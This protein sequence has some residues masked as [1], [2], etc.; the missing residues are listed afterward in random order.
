MERRVGG[1]A[2]RG[3]RW[4]PDS[5]RPSSP[6]A[7]AAGLLWGGERDSQA[8]DDD[9]FYSQMDE[10]GIIG[11]GEASEEGAEGDEEPPWDAGT[12]DPESGSPDGI[13]DEGSE[14][15]DLMEDLSYALS[16]MRDSEPLSQSPPLSVYEESGH[17]ATEDW[18][19]EGEEEGE[20]EE[21]EE[22][23]WR[24]G[25]EGGNSWVIHGQQQVEWLPERDRQLDMTDEGEGEDRDS[26]GHSHG[27]SSVTVAKR[28]A[29]YALTHDEGGEFG[30]FCEGEDGE[31]R[32]L[33]ESF[34]IQDSSPGL[35]AESALSLT[36]TLN[37]PHLLHLSAE[38]LESD[39][40]I[41]GETFPETG[42][43]ES[44]PE[45]YSSRLSRAPMAGHPQT[46]E[47][48]GDSRLFL[49]AA[50]A[51]ERGQGEVQGGGREER[52]SS[53]LHMPRQPPVPSPRKIKPQFPTRS[54]SP[55]KSWASI[56]NPSP[57]RSTVSGVRKSHR[58]SSE[59]SPKSS[60]GSPDADK[61]RRGQLSYPVPD[62]SK[63]EP[64]VRLPKRGAYKPPK[65]KGSARGGTSATEPLLMFKS[66]A[67]IVREV[68]L[69]SAEDPLS[70]PVPSAPSVPAGHRRPVDVTVPQE[71]RSPQ[72][73]SAL[74][75]QLQEDY[76]RLL[77][78][79]AEAENT[80]DRLRLEAKVG[81]YSDPPK[82][83]HFVQ[84]GT[85]LGGS[86]VMTLNFP[87]AQ[88][89]ELGQD[90][91]PLPP[92]RQNPAELPGASPVISSPPASTSSRSLV[93]QF[94]EQLTETLARQAEKFQ[95]QLDSFEGLLKSGKLKPFEQ[96]KCLSSLAQGQDSLERGY[97]RARDEHRV[98]QQKGREPGPF[99]PEREVEGCIFRLGMRLEELKERVEQVVQDRP[100]SATPPSP[101]PG[102]DLRSGTLGAGG[103][104]PHPESP[105]SPARGGFGASVGAEVSS[106]SGESDG[107]GGGDPEEGL[108]S[109]LPPSLHHKHQQVERDF[110]NLMDHYQSFRELPRLLD[111]GLMEGSAETDSAMDHTLSAGQDGIA[112]E[113][114]RTEAG[115]DR[116]TLTPIQPAGSEEVVLTPPPGPTVDNSEQ[117]P[118]EPP[119]QPLPLPMQQGRDVRRAG[120][121]S[122][123]SSLTSLGG[124][125]A[126]E[127]QPSKRQ[128]QHRRA[129]PQDGIVSPE[130]DSG[131]LGSESSRLTPAVGGASQQGQRLSHSVPS[132]EEGE[133]SQPTPAQ[134]ASGSTPQRP[135]LEDSVRTPL[136]IPR[137]LRS[138]GRSKGGRTLPPPTSS[139]TSSPQR[140]A[141]SVNSEF[142]AE[143]EHA[144]SLSDGEEG[145]RVRHTRSANQQSRR[146]CSPSPTIPHHHGDPLRA[147]G[148]S[149]LTNQHEAIQSLQ[150]EVSRLREQLEG[151]LRRPNPA[152]PT[153]APPSALEDLRH[154]D[155]V[156]PHSRFTQSWSDD[157][158]EADEGRRRERDMG[159]Q[160]E[161]R[162]PPLPTP[163]KRSASLPRSRPELDITSDSEH[164]QSVPKA[165]S[166]RHIPESSAAQGRRR[167]PWSETITYRGPYTG[168]RYD[169]TAPG[170]SNKTDQRERHCRT[171]PNCTPHQRKRPGGGPIASL[172][173]HPR[174]QQC[175]LCGGSVL[176]RD[177]GTEP[178]I[179]TER[180]SVT[181]PRVNQPKDSSHNST[182][183][184]WAAP[185]LSVQGTV[186]PCVPV[187]PPVLYFSSPTLNG[188]PSHPQAL[189][190]PLE[191]SFG[192]AVDRRQG[193]RHWRSRSLSADPQSL[194]CS[195]NRAIVAAR[196]VRST[197]RHM[198][199]SL[200]VGL[201]HQKAFTQSQTW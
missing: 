48:H 36:L 167:K 4:N 121:K 103:P 32:E 45:S 58:A 112:T 30:S 158:S 197:S 80:I 201:Q 107:E 123:S 146:Q 2:V 177:K 65:S 1:A 128:G 198:A 118:L 140:W 138:V 66:P 3:Q 27:L 136:C 172:H 73:A 108:P 63:V 97:I 47:D 182:G 13:E 19:G 72:Q 68:L 52:P 57:H 43:T 55:H 28:G 84:S 114:G 199:R 159:R 181:T 152:S 22:E 186:V 7:G 5:G 40:G 174:A 119:Q 116:R 144:H 154:P 17:V 75:H 190:L 53:S 113:C 150:A 161:K 122:H 120:E 178:D 153:R 134:L 105:V 87:Q 109:A 38:Q 142:E 37:H 147:L 129:P 51:A 46:P 115:E 151:S 200:A 162:E 148:S 70:P 44:L 184:F 41:E 179:S 169:V 195:L 168:Q 157:K 14:R 31:G 69:S 196:S 176:D 132:G 77:T 99:D 125:L 98:M 34:P 42:F 85:L 137:V 170:D 130:T 23:E 82:P 165:R 83:S 81:L 141:S 149:Q 59:L 143:S 25:E 164:A 50:L 21:E 194:S 155:S 171:C 33:E 135:P 163:R 71:F 95:A 10:N 89:A 187:C 29:P 88:R 8:G 127:R 92:G 160:E 139:I 64:R 20:E 191:G 175:P 76:N 131:F 90:A 67:D 111:L 79:Y 74:V 183:V 26:E 110:S 12:P 78:K 24:Q 101:P 96:M 18:G 16:E 9:D 35:G 117:G 11:L 39:P 86:K 173:T 133:T 91:I 94:G 189:C 106:V 185:P 49:P 166:S 180:D 102:L 15:E 61:D 60:P 188:A 56:P 126:S 156:T 124:S 193:G 6:A 93:L 145:H 54:F 100:R 62:F 192:Y 104:M